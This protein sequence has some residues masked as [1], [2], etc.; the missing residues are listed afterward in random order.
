[1]KEK[2][3]NFI[4][5]LSRE[6]HFFEY[7]FYIVLLAFVFYLFEF[8]NFPIRILEFVVYSIVACSF[9]NVWEIQAK[10]FNDKK[11]SDENGRKWV[12]F[13]R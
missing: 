4:I 1:M 11:E 9:M 13:R 5:F 12:Y 10:K 7:L 3:Y 2:F 6:L 8:Y